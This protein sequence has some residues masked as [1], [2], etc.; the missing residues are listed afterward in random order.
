MKTDISH[1]PEKQQEEL[2]KVIEIIKDSTYKNIGA[3]MIILYGSYARWDFV[4]SDIVSEWGSFREYKSDFDILVI[5]KKPTQEKNLR[6]SM[7]ISAKIQNDDTITSPCNIIIEDIYHVNKM[8]EETRYFYVDMK[9]E[10]IML[11]DSKKYELAQAKELSPER[12]LE[13]KK[14]DFKDWTYSA[15]GFLIDFGNA[16]ERWDY[17]KAAFYLH[18][19]AEGFIAAFL[20]VK[21]GYKPKTHNL[22]E[23][24]KRTLDINDDLVSWFDM[25]DD[26]QYGY[27]DLLKRSYIEARYSK[28]YYISEEE[29]EYLNK[30]VISL[31]KDVEKSCLPDIS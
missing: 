26:E 1:I 15:K 2:Q 13:I 24:Y 20:L 17:K 4:V 21:S 10:G 6:L 12:I 29:L 18:G 7:E 28:D 25:Q 16:K 22:E 11:F 14:E 19:A 8:L 23:L 30:K 9:R 27:F 31:Q 5:T 3:E